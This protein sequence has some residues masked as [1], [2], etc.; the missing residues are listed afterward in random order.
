MKTHDPFNPSL[1]G[2]AI[3]GMAGRFPGAGTVAE[4]WRNQLSGV[5]SISHLKVEE[6]DVSEIAEK[7]KA[8]NYVRARGILKDIDLFDP[9]FFGILPRE[10]ELMDPQHRIFLECCWETFEDAG[11]NPLDYPGSVGVFAGSSLPSYF[12]SR[13]CKSPKFIDSFT[14][15]YQIENFLEMM[16][17]F[18]DFLATRVSY[19]L[20]L[21][22][23]SITLQTAC[24]TSLVAIC[25][26]SQNL[27]TFQCDMAIAGGV[28]IP[29]PQNRGYVFQ[30]GSMGSIDG[31]TRT[32][33]A[34]AQGTVFGSG[35]GAV[36]LKRYEDAVR[37]GDQVYAVI[38]GFALNN[39]G[40][41][42]VGYT[43]PSVE[44]QS[45]VIAMAQEAS[46]I[47][48]RTIGYIEAHG[49]GT[50]LGD[51]IELAALSKA[52]RAHTD[53]KQFCVVGT[54]KT[55]IGHLDIASGV[56]GM[57]HATQ[58]VRSGKFPPTLHFK[59]PNPKFDMSNSPFRVNT[60]VTD[61]KTEGAPRRAGV[62]AFGVG[63]TNAHVVLEQAA[64]APSEPSSRPAELLVL[65]A[66]SAAALDAAT[67]NL[68][69]YFKSN[70]DAN[71]ADVAFT[72]E[73]G[74]RAFDHRRIL[75]A[76]SPKTP[77]PHFHPK[78]PSVCLPDLLAQAIL[79]SA[80]FSPVRVRNSPTWDAK[81]TRRNQSSVKKSTAAPSFCNLRLVSISGH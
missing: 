63:G 56:A 7:A 53:A 61:W 17:S 26:A 65:S 69:A 13:L 50:P 46:G 57:I 22:G 43:A 30:E 73:A 10:A 54:A 81:S 11:Y 77:A 4:F 67:Q 34:D 36:L 27:L 48:P 2:V 70:P 41:S 16:G 68:A 19:K 32:F 45:S 64:V 14:E 21:R 25:Q 39:D 58:I 5:E 35:V 38:R 8:A 51:P 71:L 78:I 74:R 47:D 12:L 49:T 62:S 29:L 60:A 23:P 33:D 42:R 3:V 75:V 9:A 24:S 18:P 79:A 55:N 40:S 20:N 6:L 76:R 31:H 15:G 28:S 72:L 59:K 37:D 44:G 66:R 1:E 80:S 52:F